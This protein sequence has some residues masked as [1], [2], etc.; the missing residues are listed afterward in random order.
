M[1][2]MLLFFSTAPFF[3]FVSL[4]QISQFVDI[5]SCPNSKATI[6]ISTLRVKMVV[7]VAMAT[8]FSKQL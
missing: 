3:Q 2:T 6:E 1:A 5:I 7:L 4:S 8:K